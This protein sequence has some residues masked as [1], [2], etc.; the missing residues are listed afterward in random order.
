MTNI[1]TIAAV[2]LTGLLCGSF[3]VWLNSRQRNK[4][5][6]PTSQPETTP[7]YIPSFRLSFVIAPIVLAALCIVIAVGFY[8]SLPADIEY[9]FAASSG[10][11]ANLTLKTISTLAFSMIMVAA[12]ILC[13]LIA[14]GTASIIIRLGRS[15]FKTSPP[16]FKLDG[17]IALM[18]NMVLLPQIILAYLML[19][20]FIYGVWQRHFM[21]A[22]HFSIAAIIIGSGI[23]FVA[24][25]W[26]LTQARNTVGKQ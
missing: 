23:I 19:D 8:P 14:W 21:Q 26:L 18:S 6:E 20:A 2:F 3:I 11:I 7:Q 12:Q 13:A 22:T 25:I 9:R 4:Q 17:F 10:E 16:M 15:F 24:F 5:C 1:I